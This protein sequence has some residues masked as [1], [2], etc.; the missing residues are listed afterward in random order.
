M[1]QHIL[2]E[3]ATASV[4]SEKATGVPAELLFAQCALES[5]WL[6][7]TPGNNCFGIKS[8]AGEAGRQLLTTTEWFTDQQA[9]AFVALGDS[10]SATPDPNSPV[11]SGGRRRYT[12]RDWFAMFATLGDCFT[13]RAKLFVTGRYAPFATKY[14]ADRNLDTLVHGIAPIYATDPNYATSVLTIAREQ[15]VQDA[16]ARARS[17]GNA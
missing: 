2:D 15:K 13:K 5:G 10:R 7:H 12:V 3:I 14:L 6:K 1:D 16:L 17:A 11:H 4:A 8:F 9:H